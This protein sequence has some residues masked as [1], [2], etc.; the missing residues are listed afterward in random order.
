MIIQHVCQFLESF[1]PLRLAEEWD[2]VG[3]IAGD[4]QAA[5]DQRDDVPDHH[6]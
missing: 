2:N 6:G 5:V 1:A 4:R 3:L